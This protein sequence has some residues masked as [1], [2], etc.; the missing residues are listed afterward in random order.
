MGLFNTKTIL[1]LALTALGAFGAVAQAM[2]ADSI[3]AAEGLSVDSLPSSWKYV[4]DYAPAY[5]ADDAWWRGFDD[6]LLDSLVAQACRGNYDMRMSMRAM[7]LARLQMKQAESAWWPTVSAQAGW[8]KE[9]TSAYTAAAGGR[10][11]TDDFFSIGLSAS[12]EIDVFG[13]VR[14][15]VQSGKKSWQAS[16]ADYAAAQLSL[17]AQLAEQYLTLRAYQ[18]QL[19]IA[20][21]LAVEQ[22]SVLDIAQTR[23][24]CALASGLDVSQA[25]TVLYSTQA[26]VPA[27]E[28]SVAT[29]INA[30]VLL[31][32]ADTDRTTWSERL[33]V[34][35]PMPQYAGA[36]AG[37][38]S[39]ELLRR[40]PDVA[41]QEYRVAA[42]AAAA[43][44]AKKDFLPVLSIDAA[45]GTQAHR[46]GDLFK[47]DALTYSI[48]PTL[49]WT[50]F[51]GMSRKYRVA[52]AKV[53]TIE[54]ID[55]Y[56]F[57]L[58]SAVTEV[59]NAISSYRGALR[60]CGMLQRVLA[61]SRK[62]FDFSL[63]QYRQG[64]SPFLNLLNSQIDLLNYNNSYILER[65]QSQLAVI[66][67]YKAL[68]GGWANNT[69]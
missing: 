36:L 47:K 25:K 48:A 65:L 29:T 34:S 21:E 54:A 6:P 19:S 68:G 41:A 49:T 22:D 32:G 38:I 23:H 52:E 28:T 37:D 60:R 35:A 16:Q 5:P 10:A 66:A 9:R 69:L 63:D 17:C 15:Q 57:T 18:A 53:Q 30:I 61:E 39:L 42:L 1:S 20:R 8:T 27:L 13:R 40:R 43:G 26:S 55:N 24:E 31:L 67:L 2:P 56:N 7:E 4:S 33:A 46:A 58:L 11:I 3:S 62:S 50:V 64:L 59:N 14:S 51:S 44:V 45:V 12:W